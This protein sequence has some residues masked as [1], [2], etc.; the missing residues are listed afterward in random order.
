[1]YIHP[2]HTTILCSTFLPDTKIQAVVM[3]NIFSTEQTGLVQHLFQKYVSLMYGDFTAAQLANVYHFVKLGS[4]GHR[5]KYGIQTWA[6]DSGKVKGMQLCKLQQ[7]GLQDRWFSIHCRQWMENLKCYLFW[8]SNTT[9]WFILTVK[10]GD[11]R[12]FHWTICRISATRLPSLLN[13]LIYSC[14]CTQP[15]LS[16]CIPIWHTNMSWSPSNVITCLLSILLV[17]QGI[18]L[19]SQIWTSQTQAQSHWT[20]RGDQHTNLFPVCHHLL[21][22]PPPTQEWNIS[23]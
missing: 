19:C 1:M 8:D 10:S 23:A 4:Q 5:G 3:I 6:V 20:T 15:T 2:Y 9:K 11:I 13:L 14:K 22:K 18:L 12:L 16:T 21:P 17:H 7:L